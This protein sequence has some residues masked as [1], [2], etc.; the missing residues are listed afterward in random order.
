MVLFTFCC[1]DGMVVN[2]KYCVQCVFMPPYLC[3]DNASD[4]CHE[5]FDVTR[6]YSCN[7]NYDLRVKP[8][9]IKII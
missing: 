7:N 3:K 2:E 1:I 9:F 5:L 8:I 6:L 4:G